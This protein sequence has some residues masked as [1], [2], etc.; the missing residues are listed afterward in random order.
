MKTFIRAIEVWAPGPDGAV[1]ELAAGA[2]GEAVR[3][4]ALSQG[5]RFAHGE[6]LPGKCW[7]EGRPIILRKFENSYF[8]RT[9][10]AHADGLTC[11]IAL[12]IFAGDFLTAVLVI[13]CGDDADH[14][15]AIELWHNAPPSVDMT[16]AD[17]Y[18]GRTGDT[19]ETVARQV[20]LR[21]GSGLPGL[22]WQRGGAVF[23]ADLG[24][25]SGLLRADSAQRVGVNRGFAFPCSARG[26]DTWIMTFLSALGTPIVRRFEIWEPD[27][28]N[29]TGTPRLLRSGGFCEQ[30]GM[31]ADPL[32]GPGLE[33]G[34]GSIG[35]VALTGRPAL[36]ERLADE[37][38][39]GPE[40][41]GLG[42]TLMV[43]VPVISA[44]RLNSV[45]VWYF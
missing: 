14:A 41:A 25:G 2:Y 26:A 11:G 16:L 9:D 36:S 33:A 6:G 5:V 29:T 13:F 12:P 34:Q 39:V 28:D 19:F 7:Q 44:G 4:G 27:A 22:S 31:L 42:L 18:Y 8:Q 21:R 45:V 38:V 32:P 23:M 10:A 17:G 30:T 1:L 35:R 20:S 43:A 40:A 3:F 37:A 24:R 15:G